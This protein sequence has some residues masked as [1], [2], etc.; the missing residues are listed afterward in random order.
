MASAASKTHTHA[1]KAASAGQPQR[2]TSLRGKQN[3]M[4]TTLSAAQ[5][6]SLRGLQH[7]HQSLFFTAQHQ[8]LPGLCRKSNQ[9]APAASV[10]QHCGL[11]SLR[12]ANS[13]ETASPQFNKAPGA[14]AAS[15]SHSTSFCNFWGN[16]KTKVGT[17]TSFITRLQP[18]EACYTG[19]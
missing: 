5:H 1:H 14:S 17:I 13:T 19:Q 8:R 2:L 3:S 4:E 6:Q 10:A 18:W 16:C 9:D 11:P 15:W 12:N 7:V